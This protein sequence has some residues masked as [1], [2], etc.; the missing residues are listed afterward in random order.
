M[1]NIFMYYTPS[2]FQFV[3]QHHSSCKHLFSIRVENSIDPDLTDKMSCSRTKHS[4]S[5]GGAHEAQT[6]NPLIPSV[7]LYPLIMSHCSTLQGSD[8]IDWQRCRLVCTFVVSMHAD[9][10]NSE[11]KVFN[12]LLHNNAF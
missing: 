6:S 3:S 11:P 2:N 12:P 7:T 9:N 10:K 8:L 4:D 1:L 5:A